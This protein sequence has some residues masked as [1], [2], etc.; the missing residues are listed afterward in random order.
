MTISLRTELVSTGT[1]GPIFELNSLQ[2]YIIYSI[3][4]KLKQVDEAIARG[5][6]GET[7]R[8]S[9]LVELVGA[10]LK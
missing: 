3:A 9:E 10:V 8:S 1:R 7:D 5:A 2:P 4:V 6:D